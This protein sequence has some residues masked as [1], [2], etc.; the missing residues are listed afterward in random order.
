MAPVVVGVF[1][2]AVAPVWPGRQDETCLQ[3]S[4]HAAQ[5]QI[6][7]SALSAMTTYQNDDV[8]KVQAH[9][10]KWDSSEVAVRR[11]RSSLPMVAEN[12]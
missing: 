2:I 8:V 1:M 4:L 7:A 5:R 9:S 10:F 3:R 11:S 6:A 12:A